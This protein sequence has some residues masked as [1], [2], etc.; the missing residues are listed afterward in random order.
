MRIGFELDLDL[1]PLQRR[2]LRWAVVS[3][4][5]IGALGLGV[6]FA[7]LPTDLTW[8]QSGKPVKATLLAQNL[9]DLQRQLIDPACPPGYVQDVTQ[10]GIVDCKNGVDDVVKVGTKSSAFWIDRYEASL[11]TDPAGM[12]M[13]YGA[14]DGHTLSAYP[15]TFPNNGQRVAN[16][17]ALY[18][19]SEINVAPSTGMTWFQAAEACAASG[20]RLP[21]SDEWLRAASGTPDSADC[22]TGG[23]GVR[24]T[25]NDGTCASAWGARDMIGN[26]WEWTAAWSSAVETDLNNIA[27]GVPYKIW[28]DDDTSPGDSY[29][30]DGLY[31]VKSVVDVQNGQ[32]PPAN[33]FLPAGELR[34]GDFNAGPQA[35]VFALFLGRSPASWGPNMGVRCV[36]PR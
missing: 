29:N 21:S 1:S 23:V 15:A 7:G 10:P 2:V 31:N 6:A 35:G 11:W 13:Q 19:V 4:A 32:A 18:A 12:A 34:G 28:P 8:I 24:K 16:F 25:S 17:V 27:G 33:T 5:S 3:G 30:S 14:S 22:S 36:V 26:A 20:K 9:T